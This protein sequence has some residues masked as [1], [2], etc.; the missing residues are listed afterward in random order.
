MQKRTTRD[1]RVRT[2]DIFVARWGYDQTNVDFFQVTR[3]TRYGAYLAPIESDVVCVERSGAT[4]VRPRPDALAG[5]A[6]FHR[7]MQS[8]R[9]VPDEASFRIDGVRVASPW[10][11]R[12][13]VETHYA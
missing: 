8:A 5:E 13:L 9:Y 4:V 3:V 7:L 11:G 10:D 12:D 1:Y 2:D 6:R